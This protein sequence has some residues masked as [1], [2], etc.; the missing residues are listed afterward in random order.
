[1][2]L[3]IAPGRWRDAGSAGGAPFTCPNSLISSGFG[4]SKRFPCILQ[5][6][7]PPVISG[8]LDQR[9]RFLQFLPVTE[10]SGAGEVNVGQVQAHGTALGDSLRLLQV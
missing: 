7:I 10:E 6:L 9:R 1:M 4:S 8:L 2:R 3:P 5:F